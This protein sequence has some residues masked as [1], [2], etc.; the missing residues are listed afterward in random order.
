MPPLRALFPHNDRSPQIG[1][2]LKS[3]EDSPTPVTTA[4]FFLAH[5]LSQLAQEKSIQCST[6]EAFRVEVAR[7]CAPQRIVA[8]PSHHF[9]FDTAAQILSAQGQSRFRGHLSSG[10]IRLDRL[11]GGGFSFREISELC[12]RSGSGKTQLCLSVA[13]DAALNGLQVAIL[14]TT[15]WF[16]ASRALQLIEARMRHRQIPRDV[17]SQ[18][19]VTQAFDVHAAL[20]VLSEFEKRCACI[21]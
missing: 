10:S 4:E 7:R 19:S 9:P 2:L 11:L 20:D 12:G 21:P 8:D 17:L 16:N 6:L 1:D 5:N 18:I 14:D 15:N 13:V 3:L